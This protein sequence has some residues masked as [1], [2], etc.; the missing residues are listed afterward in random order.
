MNPIDKKKRARYFV[1]NLEKLS[2]INLRSLS[3]I[4]SVFCLFIAGCGGALSDAPTLAKVVGTVTLDGEP[5]TNGAVQFIPDAS[6]GTTGRMALGAIQ[7]NGNFEL[8]TS[9][10]GDGAQVGFHLVAVEC[11]G[12]LDFDPNNPVAQEPKSLIPKR[13]M[14]PKTSTFVAEVKANEKNA[15]TFELKST[16]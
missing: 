4:L 6:Q 1:S 5:L 9:K 10:A 3:C 14:N 11:F 15:F 12:S 8:M 16:P 13:Y 7:E 2:R